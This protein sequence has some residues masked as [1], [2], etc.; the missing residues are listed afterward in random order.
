MAKRDRKDLG[1]KSARKDQCNFAQNCNIT[2]VT[3]SV[4][5]ASEPFDNRCAKKQDK[6]A[7]RKNNC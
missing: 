5:F 2:D 3:D 1:K 4:E 6:N 7:K